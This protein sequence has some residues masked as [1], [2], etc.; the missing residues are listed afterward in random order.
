LKK[1]AV[2]GKGGSGKSTISAALSVHFARGGFKVLHVGCDPK[3]DSTL[4]I[5]GG[6]RIP[7]LLDFLAGGNLR[8]GPEEFV[9]AGRHGID[10]IEAGGPRPGAGCGGRGIARMFELFVDLRLL[11]EREY[12]VVLFD[13][14]GD[15]VCGGFAAPLRLGF[16]DRAFIVVSE[17][18]LSLYAANNIAHAIDTYSANGVRLGGLILNVSDDLASADMVGRFATAISASVAGVIPRDRAIQDA[19]RR[20]LTA[21]ELDSDSETRLAI[22]NLADAVL[23]SFETEPDLPRPLS[24]DDLF[25]LLSPEDGVP[26]REETV[27]SAGE[28]L[29]RAVS[30]GKP[31][32]QAGDDDLRNPRELPTDRTVAAGPDGRKTAAALLGLLKGTAAKLN[33]EVIG[34]L[35]DGSFLISLSSPS[36]GRLTLQA[37]RRGDG[38][39]AY[40][41]AGDLAVSHT[42]PLNKGTTKVLD[43]I[44]KQMAKAGVTFDALGEILLRDEGATLGPTQEQERDA[45]KRKVADGPRHWSLWGHEA[46]AGRF[47]FQQERSRLVLS[48]LRL[49]GRAITVHHGTEACQSSEQAT[50]PSVTHFVRFPWRD[51]RHSPGRASGDRSFLTNIGDYE[52]IAGSNEALAGVLDSISLMNTDAPVCVDVSCTP[53]IAGED[54]QGTVERF[55][56]KHGGPVLASAVGG[57]DI[58]PELARAGLEELEKGDPPRV[59]AG[60]HLVGFPPGAATDE[61]LVLMQ[62]GGIAVRQRQ[63]PAVRLDGFRDYLDASAQLLWPQSEYSG[64]YEELFFKIPLKTILITPPFGLSGTAA[65]LAEAASAAAARVAPEEVEELVA[66][67]FVAARE[68]LGKLRLGLSRHRVGIALTS[69][70]AGILEKPELVCGVPITSFLEGLGLEVEVLTD[71][72]DEGRLNWW[73]GSGL[74]A[75]YSDLTYDRRLLKAGAGC[76]SLA[77][78]EAGLAGAVRTARRLLGICETPFFKRFAGHTRR[79]KS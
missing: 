48:E 77:D 23:A 2:Y 7:T 30:A 60:V 5:T 37:S 6:I 24:V 50:T 36:L 54:W 8:P 10:C 4:T 17:E 73:L 78:M 33:F 14:L 62:K 34:F 16:A 68:Q 27:E 47:F 44:V 31:E 74:S 13:V 52:L 72:E 59:T 26:S 56:R 49:A 41:T 3:A 22:E 55:A 79:Q 61:L 20:H 46:M 43:Y 75:V 66:A 12:D 53:V 76:F 70:Q 58:A 28:G 19:E 57:T 42:T 67:E 35:Y 11:E 29:S 39:Q 25:R 9:V 64:L 51:C 38:G 63:L 69:G 21:A 65:F 18:P 40:A 45:E 71:S 1:I 15:V 32:E